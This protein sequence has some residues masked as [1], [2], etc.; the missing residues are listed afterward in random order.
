MQNRVKHA[1]TSPSSSRETTVHPDCFCFPVGC[2]CPGEV[3]VTPGS[4]FPVLAKPL[5][6]KNPLYDRPTGVSRWGEEL[7]T[8]SDLVVTYLV[9]LEL[10]PNMTSPSHF[11]VYWGGSALTFYHWLLC[12]LR[13]MV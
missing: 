13:L 3:P 12:I 6:E 10:D 2:W 5:W 9:T 4:N 7:Q 11:L 8:R 1:H